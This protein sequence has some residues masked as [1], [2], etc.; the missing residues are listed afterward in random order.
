MMNKK[1]HDEADNYNR[2]SFDLPVKAIYRVGLMQKKGSRFAKASLD[3]VAFLENE[4]E[5]TLELVPV[6]VKS[7]VSS[8]TMTEAQDRIEEEVGVELHDERRKYLMRLLSSDPL[9]RMLLHDTSNPKREKSEAFQ[10]LHGAHVSGS[11][12][13]IMLIGSR[14]KLMY[15]L[16]VEYEDELLEAYDRVMRHMY[17]AYLRLFY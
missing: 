5:G 12:H 8:T 10:L 17:D 14:D 3:G 1:S 15:G 9:L 2:Y 7:Q 13:G 4:E 11:I 16:F 6:E